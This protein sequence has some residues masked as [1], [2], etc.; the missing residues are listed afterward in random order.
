MSW[1]YPSPGLGTADAG[2]L[3]GRRLESLVVLFR[4]QEVRVE[5]IR[6]RKLGEMLCEVWP[7]F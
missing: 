5:E 1:L 3:F 4:T 6:E 2:T 7:A